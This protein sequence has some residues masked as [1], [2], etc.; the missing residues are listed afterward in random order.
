MITHTELHLYSHRYHLNQ[1]L[2]QLNLPKKKIKNCH[3]L[4]NDSKFCDYFLCG[5]PRDNLEGMLY[6]IKLTL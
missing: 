2:K 4:I 1:L 3:Q 6:D 5:A